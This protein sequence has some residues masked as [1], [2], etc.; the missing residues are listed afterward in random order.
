MCGPAAI[1]IASLIISAAATG[2]SMIQSNQQAKAQEK[3]AEMAMQADRE[4][5]ALESTQIDDRIVSEKMERQ[6]QR[7]REESRIIVSASEAGGL[8]GSFLSQLANARLQS[9][10]DQGIMEKNRT[11]MQ[12]QNRA[13][14]KGVLATY[15]SRMNEAASSRMSPFT[16]GLRIGGSALESYNMYQNNKSRIK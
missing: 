3:A 10:Y 12:A 4:Q 11:N 16:A 13:G 2:Y 5:L 14:V 6:R 7:M 9:G 15:Q 1:P 8:G